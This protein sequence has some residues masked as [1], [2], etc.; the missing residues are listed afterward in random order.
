MDLYNLQN[1]LNEDKVK[2]SKN[3]K[4]SEDLS[5]RLDYLSKELAARDAALREFA[6]LENQI[7]MLTYEKDALLNERNQLNAVL[8]KL[9]QE[10]E[11]ALASLVFA[12]AALEAT[13]P[14]AKNLQ[15]QI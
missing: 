14:N 1:E 8:L 13:E 11:S 6:N 7:R 4:E 3:Q 2:K 10:K 5:N 9:Q 12:K 15:M